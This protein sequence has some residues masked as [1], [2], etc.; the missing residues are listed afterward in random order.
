MDAA[1]DLC[2]EVA[3]ALALK[4]CGAQLLEVA[5]QSLDNLI[6]I[7]EK[8]ALLFCYRVSSLAQNERGG[9]L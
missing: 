3:P 2:G 9:R 1:K 6:G 8:K 5:I 7:V 4:T